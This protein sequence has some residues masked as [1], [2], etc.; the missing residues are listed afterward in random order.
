MVGE[1]RW[2]DAREF[3]TKGIAALKKHPEIQVQNDGDDGEGVEKEKDGEEEEKEKEKERKIE[4]ACYVNR[5]LCNLEMST[6]SSPFPPFPLPT[7]FSTTILSK[8]LIPHPENYRSTLHD[9]S[10]TLTL[11]PT[12]T[13]AHYRST[14]ALLALNKY[15]LALDTC[16]RGLALTS[17]TLTSTTK[18]SAEHT[19][20]QTLKTRI[21]SA[22]CSA[23]EQDR[24]RTTA[25]NREKREE[26]TLN[27]ALSARGLRM[28][29]TGKEPDLEDARIHLEPNPLDPGS[30]IHFPLLVLYPLHQQSDFL[31]SVAETTFFGDVLETVLGEGE[32]LPWDTVN[33]YTVD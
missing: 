10:H 17:P 8:K 12:N 31:K 3:Y 24:K 15:T 19:A 23:D 33:E 30:E 1:K 32:G 16:D 27:T 20:F 4:E 21:L 5:A 22:K 26:L 11:S 9:T 2:K 29:W 18:Q 7:P 13:K 14:L 28:R 25:E 6:T